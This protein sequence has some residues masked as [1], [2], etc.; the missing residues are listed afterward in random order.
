MAHATTPRM[1][2]PAY[3]LPGAGAAIQELLKATREGGVPESTLELVHLRASQINSCGFCVDYGAKSARKNGVSDEKLFAVA[4]WREAP[5]FSDEERAA[6][7][8]AEAATRLAD[9]SDAVPDDVWDAAA[10]HYDEKQLAAIVLM[11]AVTNL[12]NRINVTVRQPA[13]VGL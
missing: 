13:G 3:V 1:T 7:A 12:F 8:L 9:T 4:A 6:L 11:V 5:Y 10:D 2:N